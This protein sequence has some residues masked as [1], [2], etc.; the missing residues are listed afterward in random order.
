MNEY[1]KMTEEN[2]LHTYNRFPITLD[3]GDGVYLYDTDGKKY[4]DFMAGIAVSGLGY[5]NVE[6]KNALKEQIDNLLHSSNL[7][8]NTTCGKAAEAL[9]RASGMDR[10][11]FTNSGAEAN[12]GALKAARKYAWQKKSGRF[13]FIAMKDSFHGRSMGALAVT[14]NKH[15]QEA[16]GPMIPGIKFANYNDLESVK[17]LVNDKT[18]AIIFE[19]VQGEGGIY[20]ATNEFIQG[21][22]KLCDEKGILLILDEIQCGMG[23]TG[24]M[25]AWQGFGVKPDILTMAKAIG[26]GI[27][28]GAFAMTEEVA[29]YSLQPGDHGATYGGNPLACTA[30]KTVIKIFERDHIVDHVNAVAPY[31]TKRLDE[32]VEEL[33]CV[34]ERKGKGL[35]QGIVVTKPLAEVNKRAIEEGILIIQAQGNVIR[36]VPPL[37]VEEKHIDEMIE[38]LKRALA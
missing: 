3:R 35:M 8:Y 24:S 13:E 6:L 14:G 7:Y 34:T 21:V 28:V 30:V 9:R 5:G 12:E 15:Y 2:L 23:R 27:P 31:L 26:N 16:F 37:I 1:M 17:Q 33:D 22:R 25:F 29:K 11:F 18:C 32:L 38:K 36:F 4:L 19:T 10:I 20:P